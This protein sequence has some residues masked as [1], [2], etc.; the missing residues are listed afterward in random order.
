MKGKMRA[1]VQY[2]PN[3][4]RVEE[5][6]IP[7][8]DP[9]ELLIK[10]RRNGI[11]PSGLKAV[12]L[13]MKW[14]PPDMK[15]YGFPGHEF[16][17]DVVEVGSKVE[18]FK[19]GDRVVS[20]LY[21]PC[22]RCRFCTR[23]KFNICVNPRRTG[24]YSYATYVKG[25]EDF[26]YHVAEDIS[27]SEASF[28]EP[29]SCV[30]HGFMMSN[31][32]PGDNVLVIG[33]GPIGLLHVQVAHKVGA[34]RVLVSELKEERLA[35]AKKLGA[36]VTL[37][38]TTTGFKEKLLEETDGYGPDVVIV[39]VPSIKAMEQ[40]LDVVAKMG[41]INFFA[42]IKSNEKKFLEL[43]PNR[44]HYGEITLTGSHNKSPI[45]FE[46]AMKL[47]NSKV[48]NLKPLISHEIPFDKLME[49][50]DIV[51]KQ[52]GLKVIVKVDE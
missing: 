44:L 29:L 4:L 12:R 34:A 38:P 1:T 9:N 21:E 6:G 47:I 35:L 26:T 13:G 46:M 19:V 14:G 50:Y 42:G 30:I 33:A 32:H 24:S 49:G 10:V 40:A 23:G 39:A 20:S 36:S 45:D 7:E 5:V 17:G 18:R 28:A 48:L 22:G 3:D 43:D 41:T 25:H 2:G 52:K 31:V 37:N 16:A 15:M 27:Y 8:I 11:C 51:E